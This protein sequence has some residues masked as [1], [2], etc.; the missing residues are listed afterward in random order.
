MFRDQHLQSQSFL[1]SNEFA[2]VQVTVDVNG[3]SD[4]L[5]IHDVRTGTTIR[6]DALEL[7]RL[8]HARHEDLSDLVA[9]PA[10]EFRA[11]LHHL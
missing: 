6:L 3:N 1:I 5:A 8:A 11:E 9:S 10:A 2:S 4:R 7:E